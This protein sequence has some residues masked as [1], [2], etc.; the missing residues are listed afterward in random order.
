MG[1]SRD[2]LSRS[3]VES[4]AGQR[5][6]VDKTA[7]GCLARLLREMYG[8]RKKAVTKIRIDVKAFRLSNTKAKTNA[9]NFCS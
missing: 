2:K 1:S 8:C 9:V 7:R 6:V 5:N 3:R 4:I